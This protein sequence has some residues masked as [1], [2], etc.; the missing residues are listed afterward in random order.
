MLAIPADGRTTSR[1][2][3]CIDQVLSRLDRWSNAIYERHASARRLFGLAT[4]PALAIRTIVAQ[5]GC[6]I[7]FSAQRIVCAIACFDRGDRVDPFA[8]SLF[9][10][11]PSYYKISDC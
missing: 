8:G 5:P 9:R 4:D 6:N 10:S 11:G 2:F 7:E 3:S 1:Y